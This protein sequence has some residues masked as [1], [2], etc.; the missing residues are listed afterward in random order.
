VPR[1]SVCIP[2]YNSAR[3]LAEA[4]E[5]VL[6][7]T[8]ANFELI[9]CDN[10]STDDTPAVSRRY[11]DPRFRYVRFEEL[12]GQGGNWNRCVGL[13]SGK[14]VALLHADDVYL[15]DF[16]AERVATL[17]RRPEVGLAFGAVDII[18]A[19]GQ[20]Q[21]R[22]SEG[23]ESFVAPAPDYFGIL[24]HRCAINPAAPLVRRACYATVGNFDERRLWGIDWQMW[25]RLAAR[26][27]VAYSPHVAACYRVHGASGTA[28]A[29]FSADNCS[30][31]LEVLRWAF[32]EMD[33]RP[34]LGR[35][36]SMRE[37]VYRSLALRTLFA[38][39]YNCEIG[40][41]A[42]VR[43]NLGW[44]LRTDRSL[45]WRPTFWA[46]GM[47]C[48]LGSW[49]YRCFRNVRGQPLGDRPLG[50]LPLSWLL[51]E[52]MSQPPASAGGGTQ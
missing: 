16:L 10:A 49:V 45:G 7:Q 15:P 5:S 14:Y 19:A 8:F 46:L 30:Q 22:Q 47:S 1:V 12:V 20:I 31:D 17:D 9:V 24:L 39:G 51:G 21:G 52:A 28:T 48:C 27:G 37:Q 32:I 41:L 34:E 36:A 3:Y 35:F 50:A 26:F 44:V 11:T 2:T 4:I 40:N 6:A 42:G 13:A 25:L 23:D 29:L 38:A 18:D 43:K 33:A